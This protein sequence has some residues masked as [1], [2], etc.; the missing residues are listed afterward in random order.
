M[1]VDRASLLGKAMHAFKWNVLGV[2]MRILLQF[3]A[4]I[5][6]ARLIE[7]ADFGFFGGSLLVYGL[8]VLM[9]DLGLGMALVQR[10]ELTT[11]IRRAA[12]GRFLIGHV[13][14]AACVYLG[15]P[16]F[17]RLLGA[18]DLR[19]GIRAMAP[20]VLISA[21]MAMPMVEL[22]RRIDFRRV[23]MAQVTGYFVGFV[24]TAIPL[25]VLGWGGWSLVMALL[26]QQF[27]MV[28]ICIRAAPQPLRPRWAKLP[29]GLPAFG[30]RVVGSNMANW[31]TENLDNLLVARF[32]GL[33]ALGVYSVS[34]SLARTPA[35]HVVN[36][37]QQV[38]FATSSRVQDDDASLVRGY[39][40]LLKVVGLVTLPVFFGAAVVADS[41]I[42][43]L[44]GE[45][46]SQ[47]GPVF[48]ALCVAMPFHA[49]MAVAGPILWGRGR[50]GVE[51]KVQI[52]VAAALL[53]VLLLLMD[54]SL[55]VLAWGVCAVYAGRAIWMTGALAKD[56]AIPPARIMRALLSPALL[57]VF[58]MALLSLLDNLLASAAV[59]PVLRLAGLMCGAGA[60]LLLIM[61]CCPQRVLGEELAFLFARLPFLQRLR[62]VRGAET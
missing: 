60:G 44:Y 29:D 5:A 42:Q 46:W 32:K 20:A 37:I 35:N 39:L 19:D 38:V 50:T 12:W 30:L 4:M 34:Y 18:P 25:A 8:A 10:H 55:A 21:F 15:A 24:L 53:L 58:T 47:A 14:A 9:A 16:W 43:G 11:D 3:G 61:V 49:L 36:M 52:G 26:V 27:V 28:V 23:Q 54:H 62:S 57:A 7:P 56:M 22:R 33:T 59:S 13:G 45:R 6:L 2:A 40:A 31:V 48:A 51:L 17:A 1:S 41:V